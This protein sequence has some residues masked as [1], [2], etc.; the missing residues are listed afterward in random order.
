MVFSL[1]K[2]ILNLCYNFDIFFINNAYNALITLIVFTKLTKVI[3]LTKAVTLT[4]A[5]KSYL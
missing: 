5:F 2:H 1:F 3:Q 4:K